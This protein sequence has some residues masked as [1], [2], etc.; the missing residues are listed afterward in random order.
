MFYMAVVSN[1]EMN[2]C[3]VVVFKKSPRKS[4]GFRT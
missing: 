1:K 3:L 4:E 2:E